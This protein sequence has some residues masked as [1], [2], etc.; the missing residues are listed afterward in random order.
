MQEILLHHEV[1]SITPAPP[2]ALSANQLSG[3]DLDLS[4]LLDDLKKALRIRP[5]T[6][7][8]QDWLLTIQHG[9][10]DAAIDPITTV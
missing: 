8:C 2:T 4:T 1:A 7:P 6:I 10:L 9:P 3:R 5:H